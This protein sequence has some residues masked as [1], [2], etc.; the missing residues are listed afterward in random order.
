MS[1]IAFITGS[2]RGIG[3]ETA[4]ALG[5]QGIELIIGC[6]DLVKGQVAVKELQ[7][8]GFKTKV[9]AYDSNNESSPNT[10][11]NFIEKEY[12]KLDILVNNAGMISEDLIGKNSSS[13]VSQDVLENTFHT[14]LFAVVALTQ[15]LLPLLMKSAAGRIVNL[16][17]IVGSLT[18]QSMDN[19]PIEPAKAFAYN[20]S[21]TALNVYTIHLAHEL[22]NTNI[23]VNS[24]HPGWVKTKLGGPHAPMG[25]ADSYKTSLRLATLDKNGPTGGFFH[26]AD[27]LPW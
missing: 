6:R 9:I 17:S 24:A 15:K 14:N 19:S 3:F 11:Y 22:K 10:V 13:A 27:A 1:K 12:G 2:N 23:K 7:E 25:I 5:K 8:L 21:K 16:S 26:E 18:L 4:K 20:A